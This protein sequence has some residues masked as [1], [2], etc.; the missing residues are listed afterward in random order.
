M[1]IL[2]LAPGSDFP[3]V[4]PGWLYIPQMSL[5]VLE[6]LSGNEHQVSI[7]EEDKAPL[8]LDEKWDLVGITVMTATA[9]RAYALAKRFRRGGAKVVLGG[10]HPTMLPE[11]AAQHADA[12][13]MGE[14]EALWPRILEDVEGNRLQRVYSS[15]TPGVL[16][17]PLV[18]YRHQKKSRIPTVSPVVATRGCPHECEFCSA[19]RLYGRRVRKIPLSQVLAQVGRHKGDYV[20]FLDDNLTAN[21]EYAFELFSALR[22]LKVKILAQ[23]PIGF[24]LDD[25]LFNMAVE[26]GLKGIFIGLETIEEKSLQHLKKSV[27]V[28]AYGTAIQKC[29]EARVML[30]GSFI[31]GLDEHDTTIFQRT[32]DFVME[33]KIPSAS[34]NVLTPYPGTPLFNRLLGEGRLLHQN[35]S[36]YDMMS[37]VFRPALMSVEELAKGYLKFRQSLFSFRGIARRFSAGIAVNPQAFLHLNVAMQR[38]TSRLREHQQNYFNWLKTSCPPPP[39]MEAG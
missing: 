39:L 34:G 19:T 37:P 35:W 27:S 16:N 29:R 31:F 5:L 10:I 3:G 33:H 7:A 12:V 32:L 28:E 18:D 22:N 36:F 24:I 8:P 25:A 26:A 38:N 20:A 9:P 17:L 23:A 13:V 14:A 2:L 30:H 4:T 11:E 6:A 1:R 15:P 21:R